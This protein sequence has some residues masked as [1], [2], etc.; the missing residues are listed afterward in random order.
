MAMRSGDFSGLLP[1]TVIRD[2]QTGQPFPGNII[3]A[4]RISSVGTALLALYPDPT[5]A[6]AAG[7][8]PA[9]NH[10]WNP[11]RPED[12]NTYSFKNRPYIQLLRYRVQ[13]R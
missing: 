5:S 4:N 6:T 3:P 2:P 10:Y 12:S 1:A 11:T 7:L 8:Q 9:N 13:Y